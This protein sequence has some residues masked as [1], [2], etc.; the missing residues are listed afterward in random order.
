MYAN[1]PTNEIWDGHMSWDDE[2]VQA[3]IEELMWC[4]WYTDEKDYLYIVADEV[5]G[6]DNEMADAIIKA[7]RYSPWKKSLHKAIEGLTYVDYVLRRFSPEDGF[8]HA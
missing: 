8:Y 4:P 3:H 6:P 1:L 5:K 2:A 7:L